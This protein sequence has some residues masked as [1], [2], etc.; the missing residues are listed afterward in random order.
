[1]SKA[2]LPARITRSTS[3]SVPANKSSRVFMMVT[4]G[5]TLITVTLGT[6]Q[7]TFSINS[8][9]WLWAT[10]WL[11]AKTPSV[12]AYNKKE[13]V[14]NGDTNRVIKRTVISNVNRFVPG[15]MVT[16]FVVRVCVKSFL[17]MEVSAGSRPWLT[18]RLN[19]S[20]N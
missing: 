7:D 1:M 6:V 17:A 20:T 11:N 8:S 2:L 15:D 10:N 16:L 19:K 5:A 9:C 14:N 13:E 12:S 18:L 3:C 4:V